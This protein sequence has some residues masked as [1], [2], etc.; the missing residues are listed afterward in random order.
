MNSENL[1]LKDAMYVILDAHTIKKDHSIL[2]KGNKIEA[3]GSYTFLNK[4]EDYGTEEIIG[5]R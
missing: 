1:V 4:D 3:I 5:G 2:L